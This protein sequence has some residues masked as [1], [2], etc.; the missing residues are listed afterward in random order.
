MIVSTNDL[1]LFYFGKLN[2]LLTNEKTIHVFTA[3]NFV[4]PTQSTYFFM[5]PYEHTMLWNVKKY[6]FL[7][8][9]KPP[10]GK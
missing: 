6:V 8:G 4:I 1:P 2:V 10:R 7:V 3:N 5:Y 9:N